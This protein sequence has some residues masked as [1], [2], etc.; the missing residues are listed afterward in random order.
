MERLR[1][2]TLQITQYD[3]N[4]SV[5]YSNAMPISVSNSDTFKDLVNKIIHS[6]DVPSE[7]R[8]DLKKS[9]VE[10]SD[11]GLMFFIL[12]QDGSKKTLGLND[13]IA[14]NLERYGTNRVYLDIQR[15]VG[16]GSAQ[17]SVDAIEV[18]IPS[19]ISSYFFSILVLALYLQN[20]IE[21]L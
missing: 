17:S 4:G 19:N 3:E 9:L 6:S 11:T 8:A 21:I 1:L 20:L 16:A 13:R 15:W 12:K 14:E 2:A 10:N 5:I 18:L 7:V